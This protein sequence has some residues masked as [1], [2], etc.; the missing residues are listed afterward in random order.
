MTSRSVILGCVPRPEN[1]DV[2]RRLLVSGLENFYS[3]GVNATGVKEITDRAAVSKG[4]FYTYYRS[5]DEFVVA[6]L[7]QYWSDLQHEVGPLL[8][9]RGDP[10]TRL[11]RYF[12]AIADD[13]E[14]HSFMLGCLIGNIALEVSATSVDGRVSVREILA[15]WE[16]QLADVLHTGSAK[17]RHEVASV[18]IESWEGAVLRAKA[19]RSRVPYARFDRVTLPL[20]VKSIAAQ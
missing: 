18:I 9:G 4:T 2:R 16:Q 8:L 7:R 6:I 14:R 11:R 19:D 15:T 5:K 10:L 3:R 1:P 13:H 17:R 20:L 12:A